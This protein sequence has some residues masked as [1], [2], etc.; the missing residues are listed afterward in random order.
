MNF[1]NRAFK[2]V[3]R[4]LSKS[5]LLILTFFVIGNFVIIGLGVSNAADDAKTLTRQK[6][7]AVVNYG[8]D[9]DAIWKYQDSITDEDELNEFYKNYPSVKLSDVR[10]L[11]SDERVSTA[12]ALFTSQ[13]YKLEEY[14]Y[15]HLNNEAEA[16]M[17]DSQ[18]QCWF[19]ESGEQH[20]DTYIE[21]THFI[22][23]NSFP[24]MIE[25]VD[26]GYEIVDGR[27][28]N[29]EE[30]DNAK[31]VLLI[32][33]A[34]SEVNNLKIGDKY[35]FLTNSPNELQWYEG[36]NLKKEDLTVEFEIIGIFDHQDKITPDNSNYQWTYPYENADNMLLM[37]ATSYYLSLIHI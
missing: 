30:I 17:N 13:G 24:S 27:F 31:L 28:Y 2:N 10:N 6:M 29:E 20:C 25:F 22:K 4:K 5:I 18:E 37:P 9:Y 21:P 11:L 33:K 1:I 14:D 15:V 16:N 32:S 19:D 35:S 34:F 7:R 3:T 12:N 36:I 26:G 23:A 8:V